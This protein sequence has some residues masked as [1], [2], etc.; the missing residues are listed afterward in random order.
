MK[1]SFILRENHSDWWM[2]LLFGMLFV[3]FGLWMLFA[4]LVSFEALTIAFGIVLLGSGLFQVI[5]YLFNRNR[6]HIVQSFALVGLVDFVL[7]I[8]LVANPEALLGLV[9]LFISLWL[10]NRAIYSI[11]RAWTLKQMDGID[12]KPNLRKGIALIAVAI[13]LLWHPE[14]IGITIGLWTA[15]AFLVLGLVR[16]N[17]AIRMRKAV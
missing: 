1:T 3:I 9:S 10:L 2:Q 15:L 8:L 4:P 13:L 5:L 14:I 6:Q 17:M 7:G 11:K 16:L 12:W